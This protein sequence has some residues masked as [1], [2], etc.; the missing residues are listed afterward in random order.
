MTGQHENRAEAQVLTVNAQRSWH[1][2]LWTAPMSMLLR[3]SAL[4][5]GATTRLVVRRL[6]V[7]Q[8]IARDDTEV[9]LERNPKTDGL[10]R[11]TDI[12]TGC[13]GNFWLRSSSSNSPE[14]VCI[15]RMS[16]LQAD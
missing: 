5:K 4:A 9:T 15:Y 12:D 10:R 14:Q 3:L 7:F 2:L 16:T 11:A 8:P 6:M 13:F 1:D